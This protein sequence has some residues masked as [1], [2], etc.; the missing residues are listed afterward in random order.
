MLPISELKKPIAVVNGVPVTLE[1]AQ[2]EIARGTQLGQ[3]VLGQMKN[4]V[5]RHSPVTPEEQKLIEERFKKLP[6]GIKVVTMNGFEL[7]RDQMIEEVKKRTPVGEQLAQREL[8]YLKY[9]FSGK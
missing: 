8:R 6:P 9:A 4:I 7:T 3:Q 1:Q 2:A 5:N